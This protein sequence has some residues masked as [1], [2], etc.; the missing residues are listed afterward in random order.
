M[1]S[2]KF[3]KIFR[4]NCFKEHSLTTA[5]VSKITVVF[6]SYWFAVN[7]KSI[8]RDGSLEGC[9]RRGP[10]FVNSYTISSIHIKTLF[11]KYNV[12]NLSTKSVLPLMNLRL[13]ISQDF[14]WNVSYKHFEWKIVL[15]QHSCVCVESSKS[16][17][18]TYKI[19]TSAAFSNRP[20]NLKI[21]HKV[22]GISST[23]NIKAQHYY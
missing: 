19:C 1:F 20:V 16:W 23:M 11:S 3:C 6:K 12:L 22:T 13:N 9:W 18:L 15:M 4:K 17:R 21:Y 5:S 10:V 8:M 14:V 7:E 2:F